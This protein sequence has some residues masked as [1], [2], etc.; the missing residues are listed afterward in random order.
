M[1]KQHLQRD[2][3]A[4]LPRTLLLVLP[5]F[6]VDPRGRDFWAELDNRLVAIEVYFF[7]LYK[8]HGG[9]GRDGL[10]T[11]CNPG[12]GV[13]SHGPLVENGGTY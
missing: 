13:G 1:H 2:R 9:D 4:S 5:I 11:G 6:K 3:H 8:L 12:D 7:T 10:G